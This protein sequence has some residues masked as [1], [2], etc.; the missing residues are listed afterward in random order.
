MP[1]TLLST[2]HILTH[3]SLQLTETGTNSHSTTEKT[4]ARGIMYTGNK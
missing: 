2:L 4:E 3:S 1:G